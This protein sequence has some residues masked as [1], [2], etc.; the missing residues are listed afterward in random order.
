MKEFIRN[1]RRLFSVA[2]KP[3]KDEYT[4]VAKITGFGILLIGALGFAIMLVS[5]YIQGAGV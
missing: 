3:K 4:K 5:Y 2:T 1:C